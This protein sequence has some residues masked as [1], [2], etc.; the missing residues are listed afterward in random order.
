MKSDFFPKLSLKLVIILLFSFLFVAFTAKADNLPSNMA[1]PVDNWQIADGG[2]FGYERKEGIFHLGAD[3][4]KSAGE[5]V[6]SFMK[7]VVKHIGIH[8]R[9][10]TVILVEHDYNG[11]KIVSLYGHLRGIDTEV[12]EGQKV[13]KGQLIGH[14]GAAGAENG[15]WSEHLHFG[16]R[17]GEYV[18]T[19]TKWVYWGLGDS[20]ELSN[21]YDPALFLGGRENILVDIKQNS[22]IITVPGLGGN[23]QVKL[24]DKFGNKIENS[25]IYA[26]NHD[27]DGG[28]D[29]AFGKTDNADDIEEIIVGAGVNDVPYVK[30]YKKSTKK[31]LRK[32]LAYN[33]NFKGG[34]RVTS[35]DLDGDGIDEII[36]GAGPGGAPHIRVFDN[37]GNVIY[38]KIFPFGENINTGADVATGDTDG[39]GR[40]EII[41]SLGPNNQPKVSIINENGQKEKEFLAYDKNFKGGVRVSA[42]DIDRDGEDEIITG[43]G[44]GGGPHV[45]VFEASGKPRGL[46]FFPFHVNFRGGVDVGSIDYDQDGKDEIIMTQASDGQ[47]WVKVY[48]YNDE[49][50]VY[51]NFLAYP[52]YFEGGVSTSG[53]K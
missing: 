40:D 39:D 16:V 37:L 1:Y 23:T 25:D 45:R 11:E 14:I 36:T 4:P 31:L 46:D 33:E 18:N 22:G 38:S 24:F 34:V 8:S 29:V 7:G 21:W 32:F 49:K 30:I 51:A 44:P 52:E 5:E 50:T 3:C 13:A 42:G 6:Y 48:R 2:G 47:A 41:V 20:E 19:D 35:G 10:G 17:K 26:S 12:K 27:F 15:Y 53:L 43:A 9:F 28:G